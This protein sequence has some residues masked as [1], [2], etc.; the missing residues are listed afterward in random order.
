[1]SDDLEGSVQA[2]A[3]SL[4]AGRVSIADADRW[5]VSTDLWPRHLIGMAG[6]NLAV[7]PAAVVWPE[8]LA[9]LC[10]VVKTAREK[11]LGLVPYGAGSSVVGG[12]SPSAG[13][14]VV[15]LKRLDR[16]LEIDP[17]RGV[18]TAQVG[19]M[20]EILERQLQRKGFTQGHF[21]SSI[22]CSTLGGWIAARGAGQ[23]SSRYGK[24]E[25]QIVGGVMVLGDGRLMR[26]EPSP[27]RDPDFDALIGAEGGLAL[28]AEACVRIHRLPAERRWRAFVFRNIHVAIEAVR[29]WLAFGV[30]PAVVRFYD[31]L[32]TWLHR[33]SHA[34]QDARDRGP[35]RMAWLG[36]NL[37]RLTSRVGNMM[38]GGLQ[39]VV[40]VQGD[41]RQ[42]ELEMRMITAAAKALGAEDLGAEPGEAWFERRYSISYNQSRAYRA[43]VAVDTMEVGCT[44]DRVAPTY[45]AVRK[46]GLGCGA[47][48]IAHFSHVYGEGGS[49]YFTL[50][51]PVSRGV[52]GYDELW[53]AVLTAAAQAGA[54]VS[55]HHGVGRLKAAALARSLGGAAVALSDLQAKTDP[56]RIL[57]SEVIAATVSQVRG[58]DVRTERHALPEMAVAGAMRTLGQVENQIAATGMTLG[59]LAQLVPDLGVLDAA[60][61]QWLWRFDSQLRVIVPMLLGVDADVAG[62]PHRYTPAPRAAMGPGLNAA[63]LHADV[64]RLWLRTMPLWDRSLRLVGDVDVALEV[65]PE[66]VA[67]ET[68]GNLRV[69]AVGENRLWTV[70]VWLPPGE[71]GDLSR[72]ALC[73]VLGSR[74]RIIDEPAQLEPLV[75]EPLF[76]AGQWQV[77][78]HFIRAIGGGARWVF[79][80]MDPVGAAGFVHGANVDTSHLRN[81]A[82]ELHV[83][84]RARFEKP[85]VPPEASAGD[86]KPTP[87]HEGQVGHLRLPSH[88]GALDNCTYCPKM[89]RFACPVA[90]AASNEALLPRQLMLTANLHKRGVR[91]LSA[92]S[93]ARLWAC[94]DCRSC[95]SFCDHNNDVASVLIAAR[96]ELFASGAPSRVR[97]YLS[98]LSSNGR[99][100]DRPAAENAALAI[101]GDRRRAPAWLFLG[102]QGS[103]ADPAP[104]HA[105][106]AL[107]RTRFESVHVMRESVSCCGGPLW[108]WGDREV[109]ARHAHAFASQLQ[110]VSHLIVDDG[111]CAYTLREIYPQVKAKLPEIVTLT[112]LLREQEWTPHREERWAVHD[113]SFAVRWLNEPS[114][115][116]LP[117]FA[118]VDWLPGSIMEGEG[119]S[120]G[121]GLLHIYDAELSEKVAHRCVRD[122][123]GGGARRILTA[124]PTCRRQ[125]R[126]V[127]AEVD[128]VVQLWHES[129]L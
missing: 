109:F 32:D 78:K 57:N 13:Q 106:L 82:D 47:Q 40:G 11:K 103:L 72:T 33:Q 65:L 25:D 4:P 18:A 63:L 86:V 48:V 56:D 67:H 2:L 129:T 29:Q 41:E 14:V 93:A 95:R 79:A 83:I 94:V 36:A 58:Q 117:A 128:D 62:E 80:W 15:D 115:K 1:M 24:I 55:H 96:T 64:H 120:C 122:V 46:A 104:A 85:V 92:D 108:R 59:P 21:P 69:A 91:T 6:G 28:W 123:L 81:V 84:P 52:E 45:E 90:V 51:L 26:H 114:I 112:S 50:A 119:G 68:C 34:A 12:A 44:W 99:P 77:L 98:L 110:G 107:A 35:S 19:I 37:P 42:V 17:R 22:Y 5:A 39:C 61:K 60:R 9:E 38:A 76:V 31:A 113:D 118:G 124:S 126:K 23:M 3:A 87:D 75:G 43:K 97:A 73:E 70:H 121:G 88:K 66:I 116:T 8:S 53:A 7:S 54:N 89:C 27:I 71:R 102:C 16:L 74:M 10:I 101:E 125:L 30:S 20:G 111:C 127:G 100:P 105:A 49:I